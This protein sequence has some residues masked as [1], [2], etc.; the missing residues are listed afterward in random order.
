MNLLSANQAFAVFTRASVPGKVETPHK[1]SKTRASFHNSTSREGN[2]SL[3]EKTI[4]T[5][6]LSPS[7]A[8]KAQSRTNNRSFTVCGKYLPLVPSAKQ[9]KQLEP[10]LK[11]VSQ[12]IALA[13]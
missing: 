9:G 13:E 8:L 11:F 5:T 10:C 1:F 4:H 6:Q 2:Q 7:L 12:T 3:F